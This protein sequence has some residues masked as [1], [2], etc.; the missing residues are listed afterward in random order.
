MNT[1]KPMYFPKPYE[2][3]KKGL[4]GTI[5]RQFERRITFQMV[6]AKSEAERN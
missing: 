3:E 6:L 1:L 5:R 4:F 2:R